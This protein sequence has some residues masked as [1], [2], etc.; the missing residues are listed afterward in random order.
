MNRLIE[1]INYTSDTY[2]GD[3]E[4]F[5]FNARIDTYSNQT[6]LTQGEDRVVKTNFGLTI[7]GYLVP[8]NLSKYIKGTNMRKAYSRSIVTFNSEL[9]VEPTGIARTREEIRALPLGQNIVQ[10]G[11]GVGFQQIGLT[12]AIG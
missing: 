7:Q 5:K 9:I 12:N 10:T 11:N 1:D 3:G 2:W 4:N 8:D 6:E